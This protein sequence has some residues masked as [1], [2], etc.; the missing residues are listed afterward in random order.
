LISWQTEKEREEEEKKQHKG[1][2]VRTNETTDAACM[3]ENEM[4]RNIIM[5]HT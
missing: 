1:I 3:L 4:A 2:T 5:Q